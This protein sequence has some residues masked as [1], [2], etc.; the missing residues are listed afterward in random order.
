[1]ASWL[2]RLARNCHSVKRPRLKQWQKRGVSE[3][4]CWWLELVAGHATSKG[5]ST[6]EST[7]LRNQ[8][9]T[10]V[11]N[12]WWLA[13][14]CGFGKGGCSCSLRQDFPPVTADFIAPTF[15]RN[16]KVGQP[17]N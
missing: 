16:V 14:L 3:R 4:S 2:S 15:T 11:W 9:A 12:A 13:H 10:D 7:P 8:A 17:A 1:M 5:K 6:A